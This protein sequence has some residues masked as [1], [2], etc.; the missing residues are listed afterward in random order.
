VADNNAEQNTQT[1]AFDY[2]TWIA[3]QDDATKTGISAYVAAQ[4]DESA[5]GLKTA[6]DAERTNAK[7]LDKQLK[8]I[9]GQ[10]KDGDEA[11]KTIDAMRVELKRANA[12][13]A[14]LSSAPKD[15][16]DIEVALTVAEAKGLI[17]DDGAVDW[18]KFKAAHP[19]LFAAAKTPETPKPPPTN[20]GSKTLQSTPAPQELIAQMRASGN[21]SM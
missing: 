17:G 11:S 7:A 16:L 1:P 18:D 4:A 3:S 6:L 21:Y 19:I 10:L 5:K 13:N 20:A 2:T 14:F 8:A 12:R 9:Q 15:V